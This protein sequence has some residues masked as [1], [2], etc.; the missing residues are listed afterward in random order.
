MG[1]IPFVGKIKKHMYE[2]F[3]IN[4]TKVFVKSHSLKAFKLSSDDCII[5]LSPIVYINSELKNRNSQ[6]I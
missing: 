1:S 3:F 2:Y 6:A 5:T 4:F